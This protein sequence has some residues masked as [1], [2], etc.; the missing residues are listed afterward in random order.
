M[1]FKGSEL[2]VFLCILG[3]ICLAALGFYDALLRGE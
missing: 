3:F 2:I 1:K